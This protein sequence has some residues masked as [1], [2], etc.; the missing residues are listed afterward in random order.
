MPERYRTSF[1]GSIGTHT[2]AD[3]SDRVGTT[4][5]KG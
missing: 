1:G 2:H 4:G 3:G 5:S